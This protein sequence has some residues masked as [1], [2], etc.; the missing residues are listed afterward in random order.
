MFRAPPWPTM[1]TLMYGCMRSGWWM[2]VICKLGSDPNCFRCS[3]VDADPILTTGG[4]AFLRDEWQET[5][6]VLALQILKRIAL[7]A[8]LCVKQV[9]VAHL[10]VILVKMIIL[11]GMRL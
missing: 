6:K 7:L 1:C 9:P 10:G 11:N 4:A 5:F 8:D 3:G 2:L